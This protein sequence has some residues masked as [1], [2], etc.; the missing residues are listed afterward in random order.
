MAERSDGYLTKAPRS[1]WLSI[2]PLLSKS[3]PLKTFV[4]SGASQPLESR[5]PFSSST[6]IS[7]LPSVSTRAKTLSARAKISASLIP[8]SIAGHTERGSTAN[9]LTSVGDFTK[10]PRSSSADSVP[11]LS[12]PMPVKTLSTRSSSY[13]RSYKNFFRSVS[14]MLPSRSVSSILNAAS[15][16]AWIIST[17]RVS[18]S[19]PRPA[20]VML[21]PKGARDTATAVRGILTG[22]T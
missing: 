2:S 21:G 16:S 14:S 9:A 6:E 1:S 10:A 7:P 8:S 13:P 12:T 4:T 3:T 15:A 18:A 19:P 20:T 22:L 11:S 17:G 5:K